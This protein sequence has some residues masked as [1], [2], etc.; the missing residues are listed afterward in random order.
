MVEAIDLGY[1]GDLR[2]KKEA[3]SCL[4]ALLRF[5]APVCVKS[6]VA[7]PVRWGSTGFCII[8]RLALRK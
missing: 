4:L 2:L 5:A 7:D 1:F 8:P 6:V 3:Q